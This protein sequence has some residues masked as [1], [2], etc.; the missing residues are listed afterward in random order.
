[1]ND[2]F[3]LIT[4]QKRYELFIIITTFASHKDFK[5]LITMGVNQS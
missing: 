2:S 1:M 3:E 4:K 5:K